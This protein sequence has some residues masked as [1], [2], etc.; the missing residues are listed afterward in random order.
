MEPED[1]S[2]MKEKQIN[3]PVKE[4]D[5]IRTRI[6]NKSSRRKCDGED[7]EKQI[8]DRKVPLIVHRICEAGVQKTRRLKVIFVPLGINVCILIWKLG[9]DR[10]HIIMAHRYRTG[11]CFGA[12]LSRCVQG[13]EMRVL[14]RKK[15]WDCRDIPSSLTL[16]TY[17]NLVAVHALLLLCRF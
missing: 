17:D 10:R 9:R 7:V 3:E 6:E 13:F 16:V 4:S 5:P 2:L 15:T 11:C 8:R 1:K 14:I 12:A